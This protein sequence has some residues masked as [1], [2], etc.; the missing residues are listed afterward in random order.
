[1]FGSDVAGSIAGDR[2]N[3]APSA[4]FATIDPA[5]GGGKLRPDGTVALRNNVANPAVSAGDP[6]AASTFDQRGIRSPATGR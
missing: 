4:V 3:V 6:L 1:M 5:T 2:E